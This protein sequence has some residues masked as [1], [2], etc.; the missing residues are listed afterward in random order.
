MNCRIGRRRQW[1]ARIQYEALQYEGSCFVTLTYDPDSVPRDSDGVHVLRKPDLQKF[2]KR[3]RKS[4]GPVRYFS[5][6]EYGDQTQRPHYHAVLFG[7]PMSDAVAEQIQQTWKLGFTQTTE[8]T[9]ERASYVAHY[10]TKKLLKPDA[11]GL[12]GRPP[13]FSMMSLKPPIGQNM[14]SDLVAFYRTETGERVLRSACDVH[15]TIRIG[16]KILPIDPFIRRKLRD[17]LGIGQTEVE[18]TGVVWQQPEAP[19]SVDETTRP[20]RYAKHAE[21][22]A[23]R[24]KHG[25]L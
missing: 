19:A 11:K 21:A 20:G 7:L 13:E 2:F 25:V 16:G 10:A 17:E 24:G 22:R 15:S 9:P 5:C 18:R 1:S 3:W 12:A 6:G 8:L 23:L 4:C 14:V